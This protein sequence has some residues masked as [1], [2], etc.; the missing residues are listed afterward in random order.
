MKTQF[1]YLK[2]DTKFWIIS[3][4]VSLA[5]LALIFLTGLGIGDRVGSGDL[6]TGEIQYYSSVAG[7]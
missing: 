6:Y 3:S 2:E 7:N 5:I 1:I 4:V